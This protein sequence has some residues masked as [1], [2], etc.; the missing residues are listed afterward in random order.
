M[1]TVFLP[2]FFFGPNNTVQAIFTESSLNKRKSLHRDS[3]CEL[4]FSHN[5]MCSKFPSLKDLY[6][7]VWNWAHLEI[8][9]NPEQVIGVFERG[10]RGE[11]V[12]P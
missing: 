6:T 7:C 5:M 3:D 12:F 2:S 1:W 10:C 4:M 8:G 9:R 11:F